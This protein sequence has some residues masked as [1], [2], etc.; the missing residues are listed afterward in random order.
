MA[1]EG[2]ELEHWLELWCGIAASGGRKIRAAARVV[3]KCA[4]APRRVGARARGSFRGALER[5]GMR[6]SSR[7]RARARLEVVEP[8]APQSPRTH[9][10]RP[11]A[12]SGPL[13]SPRARSMPPMRIAGRHPSPAPPPTLL[14]HFAAR[15][16]SACCSSRGAA[17]SGCAS[18]SRS[19][20]SCS[21]ATYAYA[22]FAPSTTRPP[23]SPPSSAPAADGC[24]ASTS[25]AG[26]CSKRG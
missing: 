26:S 23:S 9:W 24:A 16:S 15:D 20:P 12:V 13:A 17:A 10:W 3:M 1:S 8:D 22:V 14:A 4:A 21:S 2:Q 18:R 6:T 5:G 19:S 25:A 11:Q 7:A